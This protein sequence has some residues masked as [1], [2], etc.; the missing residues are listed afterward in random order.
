MAPRKGGGTSRTLSENHPM[1]VRLPPGRPLPR[2]DAQIRLPMTGCYPCSLLLLHS[3]RPT[4]VA[5]ESPWSM[6]ADRLSTSQCFAAVE[7]S[8][9]DPSDLRHAL[10]GFPMGDLIV[11]PLDH[12]AGLNALESAWSP[13]EIPGL[14]AFRI[15]LAAPL[16]DDPRLVETV[17]FRVVEWLANGRL[18]PSSSQVR[19]VAATNPA[20]GLEAEVAFRLAKALTLVLPELRVM[21]DVADDHSCLTVS[22]DDPGDSGRTHE[23]VL[24]LLARDPVQPAGRGGIAPRSETVSG[25]HPGL[26]EIDGAWGGSPELADLALEIAADRMLQ[27]IAA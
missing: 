26:I 4:S 12:A 27:R 5:G 7:C 6:L 3:G 8:T 18:H 1:A 13:A 19:L 21:I 17:L 20:N 22:G 11:L 14:E 2:L 9:L 16:S 25:S 23:L 10:A 24:P 15:Q